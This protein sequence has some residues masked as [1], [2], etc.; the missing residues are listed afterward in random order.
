MWNVGVEVSVAN[1]S[2]GARW[3]RLIIT[4]G[5]QEQI[6]RFDWIPA[7]RV[8]PKFLCPSCSK[9]CVKLHLPD[10]G[11]WTCR[12]CSGLDYTSRRRNRFAPIAR[13]KYLRAK[14]GADPRPLT[15]LPPRARFGG[16]LR[17]DRLAAQIRLHE[18]RITGHARKV[19]TDL[20]ERMA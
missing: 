19:V 1:L 17:Y 8:R 7:N 12:N 18:A 14:L 3:A 20:T 15:P 4:T 16:A 11:V 10:R 6:V 2:I 13:I 9:F 5:D